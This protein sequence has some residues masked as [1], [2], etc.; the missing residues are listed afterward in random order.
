MPVNN[1]FLT[2]GLLSLIP[3]LASAEIDYSSVTDLIELPF[4]ELLKVKIVT[5]A[6]GNQQSAT[7]APANTTT[8][9]AEDMELTAAI[10][11]DD[12]LESVPGLHI[13]RNPMSYYNPIYALGSIASTYNPEALLLLNGIPINTLYTGGRILI[14]YGGGIPTSA[15][16]R[17]EVIR[18][19]GSALYGA[20]AL[21]GVINITT[22]S[23]IDKTTVGTRLGSFQRRDAWLQHGDK[24]QD[25]KIALSV[26]FS[27]I[28]GQHRTILEDAQTQYDKIFNTHVSLA[29]GEVHLS[30][31][32]W[33]IDFNLEKNHWKFHTLYQNR[34]NVGAGAGVAQSL[35]NEDTMAASSQLYTDFSYNNTEF[36]KN[37]ELSAR[38]SYANLEY[39]TQDFMIYPSGAFGGM[40]PVGMWAATGVS[41]RHHYFDVAG[42]YKGFQDHQLRLGV[43]YRF[44]EIYKVIHKSNFGTDPRT[45]Q[46]VPNTLELTDLSGTSAAF[47][48]TKNRS[49]WSLFIQDVWKWNENWE[50]TYGGRY[51]DYSDF[52]LTFNP[53]F[54]L[55][56][57]T[58]PQLTAKLL[59][60]KAF[61]SPSFQELHQANNPIALGNPNLKPEEIQTYEVAFD[62]RPNKKWHLGFNV[63]TY[64]LTDQIIFIPNQE[65]SMY[66]AQN[67]ASQKGSGFVIEGGWQLAEKFILTGSYA[68]QRATDQ[69][70]HKVAYVPKQD[71]H[72]RGDWKFLP[73]W[74]LNT[75]LSWISDRERAFNDPRPAI[76]N[77]LNVDLAAHYQRAKSPWKVTI[78]VRNLFNS[79]IREPTPGP[80]E[81]GMIKIP[82]DLP[83]A[84]VNYFAELRYRF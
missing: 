2:V 26:N 49:N 7:F 41:E 75:Q 55:V 51:D 62:Y 47:L 63:F 32:N 58:T 20:D 9:N 74:H 78:A 34:G 25:W 8:I 12:V 52:G 44:S 18:G 77:Y 14:G 68:F 82:H 50:V 10:D 57:K 48:P 40:Y 36:T 21:S 37:W 13:V 45:Q 84:G 30:H 4:E 66:Y 24:Y 73:D 33:D 69:D 81:T 54:A 65:K 56:W 43:S 42:N 79:D 72:L 80:D 19:P 1:F 15:I 60:G 38:V 16:E 35:T 71:I 3:A 64:D 31:R 28:E 53:R 39:T 46:P 23:E 27:D 6:T 22:K 59:Y 61:R 83:M 11:V 67:T 17:I 29:P 70:D 76:D 5:I